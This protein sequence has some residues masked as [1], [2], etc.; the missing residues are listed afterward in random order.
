MI[1]LLNHVTVKYN[2]TIFVIVRDAEL[3]EE[4]VE[5]PIVAARRIGH[6]NR[7][8]GRGRAANNVRGRGR[9]ANVRRGRGRPANGEGGRGRPARRARGRPR[10]V[11]RVEQ[12]ALENVEEDEEL[13][14]EIPRVEDNRM[15][16]G[17]RHSSI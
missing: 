3:L 16:E 13:A 2:I 4:L 17:G 11:E 15:E 12:E 7:G 5:E 8:G 10:N 14:D 9:P 1:F 6:A